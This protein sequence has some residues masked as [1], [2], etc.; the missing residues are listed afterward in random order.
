[1]NLIYG[2][3]SR[4][5]VDIRLTNGYNLY[6]W[7]MRKSCFPSFWGR[8]MTGKYAVTKEEIAFLHQM[9]CK[10]ALIANGFE[11][12]SI[13]SNNAQNDAL[14]TIE[15]AKRL[16]VPQNKGITLFAEI[17]GKLCVNHNWMIG[18]A[19]HLLRNGYCPGFIGDTDSSKNFNFGR[20]CSHYIQA[21]RKN[22][23]PLT[24]YWATAPHYNFDPA[25]WAPYAP[26]QILPADIHIWQYGT[27]D[28][29]TISAGKC[30]ARDESVLERFY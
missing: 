2:A 22:C 4:T 5:R 24:T 30:Y 29:H 19:N 17:P 14:R 20:Q 9:G 1:M 27:V 13:A 16:G 26:S 21:T 23:H 18:Y 10:V 15:A 11:E 3:D 25:V 7:V 6:E 8:N 28:F 12:V